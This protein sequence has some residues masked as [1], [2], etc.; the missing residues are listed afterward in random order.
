[1]PYIV[2]KS[3]R[4]VLNFTGQAVGPQMSINNSALSTEHAYYFEIGWLVNALLIHPSSATGSLPWQV[5][6]SLAAHEALTTT[7]VNDW[8]VIGPFNDTTSTGLY[9][10][11]G[12]VDG[13]DRNLSHSHSGKA[14]HG[15]ISW[16]RVRGV[17]PVPV[18]ATIGDDA[19][20]SAAVLQT[21]VHCPAPTNAAVSFSTAGTGVLSVWSADKQVANATDRVY[22]GLFEAE[23][24]L[25]LTLPA[26][27]SDLQLK[28]LSHFSTP[29]GWEAQAS[30]V[31]LNASSSCHVDACG[32]NPT[33]PMCNGSVPQP[34][35]GPAPAVAPRQQHHPRRVAAIEKLKRSMH[36]MPAEKAHA[37]LQK[38]WKEHM[39]DESPKRQSK[40]GT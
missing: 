14:P 7:I 18:S 10:L 26:G 35:V 21:S 15:Q 13:N 24:V 2:G 22:A 28:T 5:Q 38:L 19:K 40:I 11:V 8:A 9:R 6:T 34:K 29:A 20:G 37:E 30:I 1:M 17:L 12:A 36:T 23:V 4:L 31:F 27:W 32:Q 33:A 3:N 25:N 39:L 16:R